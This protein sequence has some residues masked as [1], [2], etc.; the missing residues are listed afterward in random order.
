MTLSMK[1]SYRV[2]VV[3]D[4]TAIRETYR[5]I[6]QPP[7][8]EVGGLEA[9]ISGVAGDAGS[10]DGGTG[11]A[12]QVTTAS[13]GQEAAAL[14]RSALDSGMPFQLAFIDMRM[15]PGWDG[16]RTAVALRAQDPSI[17]IVIATAFSDYN[18]NE[19]QVAL[20]HDVVLLRKPFNQEE[21]YQL[22]RTL[23]Q[24]WETRRRLEA[25]TAELESRVV[26]RTAELDSRMIQQQAL[27]EIAAQFIEMSV[28][29]NIDDAVAWSLARIGR[30]IDA[31]VCSLYQLH[32]AEEKFSLRHEWMALGV[33]PPRTELQELSQADIRP[34]Y[35][36]FL[37]GESFAINPLRDLPPEMERLRAV[38]AGNIESILAVPMEI[39]GRLTGFLAIGHVRAKADWDSQQEQLLCTVGHILARAL[40][41]H[42]AGRKILESQYL[43]S[44][45]EHAAHIGNWSLEGETLRA[46]WD[47]E[48]RRI[49][50]IGPDQA[51]GPDILAGLV[52]PQDWPGV[53]ASLM[54]ALSQGTSHHVEYRIRRPNGEE[55]WVSCWAEPQRD[56][57]GKIL[58]L[59]GMLQDI[60]ERRLREDRLELLSE[61]VEQSV[62]SVIITDVQ[63]RIEYTNRRFT[64][65]TG[66]SRE[67]A[68]GR[69]PRILKSDST[70]LA[71]YEEM[72]RTILGGGTWQGELLNR[73]KD[74]RL[75]WEKAVI[76]GMRDEQ[77]RVQHFLAVKEDVTERKQAE[78]GLRASEEKYRAMFENM[79]QG[80]FY[81]QADGRLVDVNGA[82]L[83]LFGLDREQFLDMTS[84]DTLWRAIREDG[85]ELPPREH[86]FIRALETGET[87]RHFIAG[88]YNIRKD[89]YVWL[90][91]NAIPQFKPGERKPYQ[92]FVTLDDISERLHLEAELRD[93]QSSRET[94]L[95]NLPGMAYR[96]LADKD[97]TMIY[98]SGGVHE[99]TGYRREDLI[100]SARKL[101]YAE[102][103]HP[104][105]RARVKREVALGLE[106]SASFWLSYRI[107]RADGNIC[108][109]WERGRRTSPPGQVPAVLEGFIAY[110]P[111]QS[112]PSP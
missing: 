83:E 53:Q 72:W 81:Q 48:I 79:A 10:N 37:R 88:V 101:H 34:A 109:V 95:A 3:D 68:I 41:A 27:A 103:I 74:G 94:L 105:D 15:P 39:S 6:L 18:V 66:Y 87:I 43:L 104:Q 52:H 14:H 28:E 33:K 5:H 13:Q 77:G 11:L 84:H 110:A 1:D 69:N 25:V 58:R 92:V 100:G 78:M 62:D 17:Y 93:A 71:V 57:A 91:I 54:S 107:V 29:E 108:Q 106:Q 35:A 26:A 102:I 99:L 76:Q 24:S 45:T 8:S 4:D 12:F 67:E 44:A 75:Y 42:D 51:V 20:G 55:R 31:D 30:V 96:C 86:P 7:A 21:V 60:T 85:S 98:V 32:A 112:P 23:C 40:E 111:E 49:V 9:L 90:S 80:A 56:A 89:A 82:A 63:G 19:L 50:G 2:L 46:V 97:W 22:A 59:V 16:M 70:P 64:E 73:R 38:L 36:R 61:A 65:V 47:D